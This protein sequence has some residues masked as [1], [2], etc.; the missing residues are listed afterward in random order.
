MKNSFISLYPIGIK[1]RSTHKCI[2]GPQKVYLDSNTNYLEGRG[3][4]GLKNSPNPFISRHAGADVKTYI[5][6][7]IPFTLRIGG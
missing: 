7:F 2:L 4:G 5:S 6:P 1:F 3:G